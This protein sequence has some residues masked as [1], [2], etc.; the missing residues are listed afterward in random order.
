MADFGI[1]LSA[2]TSNP[3]TALRSVIAFISDMIFP[4]TPELY[5]LPRFPPIGPNFLDAAQ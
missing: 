3:E 4:Y 1:R 2:A 5:R